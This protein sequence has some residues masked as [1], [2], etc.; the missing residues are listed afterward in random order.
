[1]NRP[2]EPPLQ[3]ELR[4]IVF[5]FNAKVNHFQ[6]WIPRDQGGFVEA[7]RTI[8]QITANQQQQQRQLSQSQMQQQPQQGVQCDYHN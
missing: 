4:V 1:M 8:T 3:L 5:V 7:L 2:G 6:G